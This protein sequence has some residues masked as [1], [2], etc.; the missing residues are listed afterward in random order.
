MVPIARPSRFDLGESSACPLFSLQESDG[1]PGRPI[2]DAVHGYGIA[3][4]LGL[5]I[6]PMRLVRQLGAIALLCLS[7]A[8]SAWSGQADRPLAIGGGYDNYLLPGHERLGLVHADLLFEVAPDWWLGPTVYG[9]ATGQRGGFFVG[10]LAVERP[11]SLTPGLYLVPG[12]AVGGGGGGGAPVG[13]GLMLRPSL[14]LQVPHGPWRVGLGVSELAFAGTSIRSTRIGAVVEWHGQFGAEPL[15]TVGEHAKAGSRS[16]LGFDRVAL[17][18]GRYTLRAGPGSPHVDLVGVRLDRLGR[19]GMSWGMEAAA[20]ANQGNSGYMEIL[21]HG[22]VDVAATEALRIGARAALGLGGGGTV[23]TGG[24]T[25]GHLDATLAFTP[26]PGWQLGAALG[27][28]IGSASSM[29]GTRA[30]ISLATGLEP[31]A[32][33]G[34]P[35]REGTVR[36]IDWAGTL[37]GLGAV[38]RKDGRTKSLETIGWQM[39]AWLSANAYLTAQVNSAWG[40]EAGAYAQGLMGAGLATAANGAGM[41]LGAELLGG[42]AG[43]GGVQSLSGAVGQAA[44]WVAWMPVTPGPYAR[45]SAGA[46]TSRH[47]PPSPMVALSWVVPFGQLVR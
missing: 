47:G 16:G 29:R 7:S 18:G 27:R 22:G 32:T 41:R 24:G 40:G 31:E 11:L 4:G 21:A 10:G 38:R 46:E 44:F 42:A 37:A 9:A 26:T 1:F 34:S 3:I 19:D 43:G 23:P 28:V 35:G 5:R 14:S 13:N 36:Q 17:I 39:N 8:E 33:P 15:T 25:I 12:L 6:H 30:E 20:A 2:S 45:L